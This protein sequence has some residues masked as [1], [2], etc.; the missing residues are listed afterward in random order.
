MLEES[1]KSRRIQIIS[2]KKNLYLL[3]WISKTFFFVPEK[4][5]E[6]V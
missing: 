5:R 2:Q 3:L 6:D 4:R 1:L